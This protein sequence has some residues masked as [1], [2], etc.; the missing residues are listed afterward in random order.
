MDLPEDPRDVSEV[1][2]VVLSRGRG[3]EEGAELAVDLDCHLHQSLTHLPHSSSHRGG[4]DGG[5]VGREY[6]REDGL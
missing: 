3:Q 2:E 6:G 1:E 5:E 4:G